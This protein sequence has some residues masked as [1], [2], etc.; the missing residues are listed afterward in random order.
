MIN[1][2]LSTQSLFK[3]IATGLLALLLVSNTVFADDSYSSFSYQVEGQGDDVILIPGLM[4][5]GRVWEA[6]SKSLSKQHRVHTINISGFGITPANGTNSIKDV[7]KDLIDYIST[8]EKPTLEKPTIVG[9]SI[10]G[11]LAMSLAINAPDSISNVISVDGLPFIGPIFTRDPNTRVSDLSA[12]ANYIKDHYAT[13]SKTQ[14]AAEV[15]RGIYIQATSPSNQ[16]MIIEMSSLSDS[17]TIGNM[18][19]AVMTT[20]L[21][22]E[23]SNI[24]SKILMLGASGA[25]PNDAGKDQVE[26]L[27]KQQFESLP[28]AQVKMNRNARHFIM[29]DD[30]EWLLQNVNNLMEE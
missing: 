6:T 13:L 18:M 11:F 1:A 30:L 21:R 20:D 7:E 8:L 4:S 19:H 9:H 3:L 5:D 12:Q 27:Y 26:A 24:K 2:A 15:E 29:L 28:A 16:K 14:L 23:L 25:M 17:K 22:P 10:G